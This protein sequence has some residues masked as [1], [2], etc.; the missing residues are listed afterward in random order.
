MLRCDNFVARTEVFCANKVVIKFLLE[1]SN[2]LIY[3]IGHY[4][5]VNAQLFILGNTRRGTLVDSPWHVYSFG[6]AGG[7][8]PSVET[9]SNKLRNDTAIRDEEFTILI[10]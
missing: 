1:H 5:Y 7:C 4:F 6:S 2:T 8:A 10:Q 9:E 3:N